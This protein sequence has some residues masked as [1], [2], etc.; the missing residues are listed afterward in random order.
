MVQWLCREI[1]DIIVFTGKKLETFYLIT[2]HQKCIYSRERKQG[3]NEK[4]N[5]HTS[6]IQEQRC[7]KI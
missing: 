3:E 1:W 6:E 5:K 4:T 7:E 2:V